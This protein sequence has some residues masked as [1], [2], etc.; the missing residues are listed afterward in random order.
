MIAFVDFEASALE[1]SFPIEVGWARL[2]GVVGAALIRPHEDWS[3][4]VWSTESERIHRLPRSILERGLS[5]DAALVL[6]EQGLAG[7]TCFSDAPDHDWHWLA[8]LSPNRTVKLKL[9]QIPADSV[10]MAIAE[11]SGIPGPIA[12]CVID[13]A[14]SAG[15]HTACGDAAGLAAGFEILHR[16]GEIRM[17]DVEA[18]LDQWQKLAAAAAPWRQKP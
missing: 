2:D 10:L 15:G 8:M 13:R 9:A 12:A 14:M 4:L 11:Y 3:S 16:G 17:Q 18:T 6:I 7:Y 1:N 5:I